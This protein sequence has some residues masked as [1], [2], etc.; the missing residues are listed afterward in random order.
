VSDLPLITRYT[1]RKEKRGKEEKPR[2]HRRKH[3]DDFDNEIEG[4]MCEVALTNGSVLKGRV[5]TS[6]YFLKIEADN[7]VIYV[8]K[9]AVALIKPLQ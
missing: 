7:Q 1:Q 4:K 5:S 3:R 9:A 2:K 8:N 6:R